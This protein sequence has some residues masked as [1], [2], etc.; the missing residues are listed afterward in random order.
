MAALL[1]Q[2][3]R[4]ENQRVTPAVRASPLFES[5]PEH[6]ARGVQK[7]RKAAG[8]AAAAPKKIPEASAELLAHEEN[9]K[10]V[11]AAVLANE[12]IHQTSGGRAAR[13][14]K[15]I[16]TS[17]AELLAHEENRKSVVAAFLANEKIRQTS[18]AALLTHEKKPQIRGGRAAQRKKKCL[19]Q[20]GSTSQPP[21]TIFEGACRRAPP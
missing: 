18:A 14:P 13:T 2:V 12:K 20:V 15:K 8:R 21:K 3:R 16:Q 6:G 19:W 1:R 5:K 17:A 7:R 11:V 10:S 4:K 9:R